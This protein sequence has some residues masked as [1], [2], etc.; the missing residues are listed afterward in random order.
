MAHDVFIGVLPV[1]TEHDVRRTLDAVIDPELH[2]SIE[3]LG[4]VTGVDID[5]A[6]VTVKVALT[7]AGCPLRAQIRRDVESK[8]HGLAGVGEIKVEMGEMT[9]QE[10]SALMSRA[11]WKARQSAAPTEV[12]ASCRVVAVSSGKGGVGKSTIAV[13]VAAALAVRGHQVGVLDAD[14]WGFSIPRMLGMEGRLGGRDDKIDPEPGPPVKGIGSL[15][16]VSMGL[17]VDDER[18]ALMWRGLVLTRALEQFLKDVR[19]GDDLAYLIIDMPPGTGDIQMALARLLP[20]AEMLLVTTPQKAAQ[21]VAA[22]AASMARR[23]YMKIVGVVENMSGF[24][25][26][27]G[28]RYELFGSGGGRA[29]A[30][31]LEVG[32]LG[33]VPIDPLILERG[34]AGIPVALAAPQSPSGRA[35]LALADC[36]VDAL[37]PI[38][39]A[40]CTARMQTLLAEVADVAAV[41]GGA[42]VAGEADMAED[43]AP[44]ASASTAQ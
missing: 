36:V 32:L 22:R 28:T 13:N 18:Q 8:L 21:Q 11:R 1:I 30:R 39:M 26:D 42:E 5:G 35:F 9:Q 4:M 7:V 37:P 40:G 34:D 33:Q 17:L 27:H 41:A 44:P 16:V 25:C 38:E 43:R 14:I 23:S 20:Q 15:R 3:E 10:R 12:P 29:L 6:D 19:W 2:A 31:E 24:E